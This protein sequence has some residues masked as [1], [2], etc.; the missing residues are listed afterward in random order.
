MFRISLARPLYNWR[1]SEQVYSNLTRT[2]VR[3]W[4]IQSILVP[5][6][7]QHMPLYPLMSLLNGAY[8]SYC[9]RTLSA[10]SV[11]KAAVEMVDWYSES[12]C[13]NH[14]PGNEKTNWRREIVLG[15]VNEYLYFY[16]LYY[17]CIYIYNSY[18]IYIHISQNMDQFEG[19]LG[20][21][22]WSNHLVSQKNNS[23]L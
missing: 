1:V 5:L 20:P 11:F 22:Q 23:Q 2:M 21:I 10:L 17:I 8:I 6:Y 12:K 16:I 9:H 19:Q 14:F 3:K 4:V 18:I 13:C 15:Y 7:S